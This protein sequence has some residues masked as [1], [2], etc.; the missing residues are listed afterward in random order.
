M[1][2]AK[3]SFQ[4][5]QLSFSG[6]GSE[7]WVGKQLQFLLTKLPEL[8]SAAQISAPVEAPAGD[9][10]PAGA[11]VT[12]VSTLASHIKAKGG[13]TVQN[14]RFLA[15]A[16]WLRLKGEKNLK[17]ALVSQALKDNHQ[18]RLSNPSECLNQNVGQGFCEKTSGGAFYITPEGPKVARLQ[19]ITGPLL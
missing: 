1:S 2:Q 17:T 12:K 9:G 7:E 4:L 15:T 14:K 8:S 6:E 11:D 10:A 19:R 5:G 13:E 3:V 18:K 16:D